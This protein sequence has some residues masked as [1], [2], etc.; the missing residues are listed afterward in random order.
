MKR[1]ELVY[2]FQRPPLVASD[3]LLY[4]LPLAAGLVSLPWRFGWW[5]TA[6]L[7]AAAYA[8]GDHKIIAAIL[9]GVALKIGMP[10][11]VVTATAVFVAGYGGI[12][13]AYFRMRQKGPPTIVRHLPPI[14]CR[15]VP[16]L[17]ERAAELDARGRTGA[18][19]DAYL[20]VLVRHP[21]DGPCRA[22]I[23]LHAAEAALAIG[24]PQLTLAL[25]RAARGEAGDA[26]S[27]SAGLQVRARILQARAW[28][29]A[30]RQPQARG[31]LR[32]AEEAPVR[33]KRTRDAVQLAAP[34]ILARAG[35][36]TTSEEL[37]EELANR[38]ISRV[39]GAAL[40]LPTLAYGTALLDNDHAGEAETCLASAQ[41]MTEFGRY[42]RDH[43]EQLRRDANWTPS[44]WWARPAMWWAQAVEGRAAAAVAASGELTEQ[45]TEEL[46]DAT[47]LL[48]L[49]GDHERAARAQLTL[50]T[51]ERHA[52]RLQAALAAAHR[53][54]GH[55]NAY[56]AIAMDPTATQRWSQLAGKARDLALSAARAIGDADAAAP[57]DRVDPTSVPLGEATDSASVAQAALVLCRELAGHDPGAFQ[58]LLLDMLDMLAERLRD[59][60]QPDQALAAAREVVTLRRSGLDGTPEGAALLAFALEKLG[61]YL[62]EARRTD[63]AIMA[64]RESVSLFQEATEARPRYRFALAVTDTR[65]ARLLMGSGSDEEALRFARDAA[66][67][68]RLLA[69]ED[70]AGS[71]ADWAEALGLLA[72]ACERAG[73]PVEAIDA[74]SDQVDLYRQL[75]EADR[76]MHGEE[77]ADALIELGGA[78]TDNGGATEAIP[79]L[80][81][82]LRVAH[83]LHDPAKEGFRWVYTCRGEAHQLAG[84]LRQ[85]LDDFGQALEID[86]DHVWALQ[87]RAAAYRELRRHA[88]ALADLERATQLEPTNNWTRYQLAVA[89]RCAGQTDEAARDL[90]EAIRQGLGEWKESADPQRVAFNLAVYHAAL[91]AWQEAEWW[92]TRGLAD[93]ASPEQV[94]AA[95]ADTA[96]LRSVPGV[97]ASRLDRLERLLDAP[98]P[99]HVEVPIEQQEQI[100]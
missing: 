3:L 19:M 96:E 23:A 90:E 10:V 49:M 88:D 8:Y 76:T 87:S 85:A 47:A 36:L 11:P 26:S 43:A 65:L 40:C 57:L 50:A 5:P 4:Q 77:L 100:R 28:A 21:L 56:A 97:E 58:P 39:N 34:E 62:E 9:A 73:R 41:S 38:R 93:H 72:E 17:A 15:H 37:I 82:A 64:L 51:A 78:L 13:R 60:D 68:H 53:A 20:R 84:H 86:P 31:E 83:T 95:L 79:V 24:C 7:A 63:A 18:A 2:L 69:E 44:L 91:G 54:L 33:D 55:L 14:R 70:P 94:R 42:L 75:V 1:R 67:S 32:A 16:E 98:P 30:G 48:V 12:L 89:R 6:A 45:L 80:D 25:G 99:T 61:R 22:T 81:E 74:R 92:C 27:A 35:E 71:L 59:L 29:M 66:E 46:A 52:D